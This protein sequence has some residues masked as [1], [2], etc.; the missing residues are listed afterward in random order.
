ML[1]KLYR[2]N[3][4]IESAPPLQRLYILVMK[5]G[6]N[7]EIFT[8]GKMMDK[9][10]LDEFKK[11]NKDFG[12]YTDKEGKYYIFHTKFGRERRE[13]ISENITT[14]SIESQ[15]KTLKDRIYKENNKA[16]D[17][18]KESF[19]QYVRDC[20]VRDYRNKNTKHIKFDINNDFYKLK[21]EI[22]EKFENTF[23]ILNE[24]GNNKEFEDSFQD[25]WNNKYINSA[26]MQGN[27]KNLLKDKDKLI[28]NLNKIKAAAESKDLAELFEKLKEVEGMKATARELAYYLQFK[29]DNFP[30]ANDAAIK[31][32]QYIFEMLKENTGENK[33]KSEGER[34][35]AYFKFLSKEL[36]LEKLKPENSALPKYYILD[37]F[38]NL[39]DKIK[40]SDLA[41][42][43]ETESH[44]KLYQQAWEFA[45]LTGKGDIKSNNLIEFKKT[46]K[47][48][49]NIIYHGVPGTGKTYT[50]Q[51]NIK[52]II[53]DESQMCLTQFH[54][55]FSY[56]DFIEGIKPVG[57]E[58]GQLKLEL[59]DGIF[60]DFCKKAQE[61]EK[62]FLD[63]KD[64]KDF[65]EAM[66]K[67]GY[68][69][70]ADEINRA[71]LSRVF[72]ELL[73]ALEYR[74]EKYTIKTQY[75]YMRSEQEEFFVPENVFFLG[76]MND[77]DKSIDSFDLALRRRFVWIETKCDY[78]VIKNEIDASNVSEY[79]TACEN[80]NKEI[81]D[82]IGEKYQIGHS[83]FLKINKSKDGEISNSNMQTLFKNHFDVL[84][85]E[86][87]RSEYS[88]KDINAHLEKFK[89]KFSLK[90][91]KAK[92]NDNSN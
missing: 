6:Y 25:W 38:L 24:K 44:Y 51:N 91:N 21:S 60:R 53:S 31:T 20:H 59:K 7:G 49:Q 56:E 23:K 34:A 66:E 11:E 19:E 22:K 27:A 78:N 50:I 84:L 10:I 16:F 62:E 82:T 17:D 77:L 67:F 8:K 2:K 74:G 26:I 41:E 46:L 55:S 64:K 57:I 3:Q 30:L 1:G 18:L 83:Y 75:A 47:M 63:L 79:T 73:Y 54:P 58:N 71:E 70:I 90:N 80:L 85:R 86:Y 14:E 69:F 48:H 4:K 92:Q 29:E 15:F 81:A 40:K 45:N 43:E 87:L 65:N 33:G 72:G 12:Y 37:Q 42:I 36:E 89:E 61:Y 9:E 5:I 13:N 32:A 76:T 35:D 68:F 88:E 39:I 52:N 28:N